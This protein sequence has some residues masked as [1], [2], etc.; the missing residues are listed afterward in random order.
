VLYASAL[1]S[2]LLF[3]PAFPPFEWVVLLPLAPVPWL[4][5]LTQEESRR[6][7]F[8]SGVLFGM[9][10]W[11]A[12]IPWIIYVVTHYGGQGA[13]MGVVCLVCWA[14]T[15]WGRPALAAGGPPASP[16]AGSGA[17]LAFSPP[18]GMASEP[19]RSFVYKGFPWTLAG[20]ALYRHSI[21]I[22]TASVWGV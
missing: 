12:S 17:R 3:A 5:A 1:V 7:A 21:W 8:L 11:C 20:H 6:R 9:A 13:A 4:V 2:G 18:L 15:V 22:Q 19:A 10:Y 16:R 14:A